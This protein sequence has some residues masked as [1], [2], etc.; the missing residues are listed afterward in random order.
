MKY[1]KL[2]NIP[3]NLMNT[4]RYGGNGK[5][6]PWEAC[7]FNILLVRTKAVQ[8]TDSAGNFQQFLPITDESRAKEV[9]ELIVEDIAHLEELSAEILDLEYSALVDLR[10]ASMP[11][12]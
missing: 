5:K 4:T 9:L 7:G 8:Y 6:I 12:E 1:L 10:K 3:L 11:D 2:V